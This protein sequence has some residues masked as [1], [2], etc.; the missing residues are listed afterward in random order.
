[1]VNPEVIYIQQTLNGFSRLYLYISA[2][3]CI[4]YN[5]KEKE[6]IG[7]RETV[8]SQGRRWK[9]GSQGELEG[10]KTWELCNY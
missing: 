2:F 6:A 7:L 1:M 5:N 4:C 9:D 3:R 8:G 10:G